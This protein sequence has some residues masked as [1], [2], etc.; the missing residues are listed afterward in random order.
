MCTVS[1][2]IGKSHAL[3][4]VAAK[5]WKERLEDPGKPRVLYIP[6]WTTEPEKLQKELYLSFHDD[7]R[8]LSIL[9][10]PSM[11]FQQALARLRLLYSDRLLVIVDQAFDCDGNREKYVEP[12]V[13]FGETI[14][15][16]SSPRP[17]RQDRLFSER[18]NLYLYQ[19]PFSVR[20]VHR[21]LSMRGNLPVDDGEP[22]CLVVS[23]ERS[24]ASVMTRTRQQTV[25]HRQRTKMNNPRNRTWS[26]RKQ[27]KRWTIVLAGAFGQS[28]ILFASGSLPVSAGCCQLA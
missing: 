6:Q 10:D 22:G 19:E 15:L 18:S 12:T 7:P 3:W 25:T 5:L 14:V 13:Y 24:V 1:A 27:S 26:T 28:G 9:M 20:D 4:W 16:A 2:G 8:A 21:F 23:C 17:E 11:Q